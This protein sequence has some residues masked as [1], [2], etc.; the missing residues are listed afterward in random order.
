MAQFHTRS[1]QE[2]LLNVEYCCSLIGKSQG[3]ET[4]IFWLSQCVNLEIQASNPS[5]RSFRRSF[6]SSRNL[7]FTTPFWHVKQSFLLNALLARHAIFPSQ[8][9][10]GSSRNLSF[11]TPFLACQVIF[12]PQ[13]DSRSLGR[14]GA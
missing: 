1:R 3:L 5:P 13:R 14:K 11:P 7:S 2:I 10:F 4:E 9:P 6:G 8:R 12:P